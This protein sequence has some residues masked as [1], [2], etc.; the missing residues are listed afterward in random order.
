MHFT[1]AGAFS[2]ALRRPVPSTCN[3]RN[4]HGQLAR[5]EGKADVANW[6]KISSDDIDTWMDNGGPPTPLL[7]RVKPSGDYEDNTKML[8]MQSMW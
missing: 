6:D 1:G 3:V 5:A 7:V 4:R 2:T 8:H